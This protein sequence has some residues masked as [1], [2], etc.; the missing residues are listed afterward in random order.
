MFLRSLLYVLSAF[1]LSVVADY[2]NPQAVSGNT[3]IHDPSL[4]KD[5]SGKYWLFGEINFSE[6][7]SIEN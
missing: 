1:A 5:S 3:A 7:E 2:P 6:F 4:C